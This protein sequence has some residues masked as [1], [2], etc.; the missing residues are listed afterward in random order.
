MTLWLGKGDYQLL[1]TDLQGNRLLRQVRI[2]S[3]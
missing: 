1:L 2:L 3:D